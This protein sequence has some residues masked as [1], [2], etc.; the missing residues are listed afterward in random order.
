MSLWGGEKA[1][2]KALEKALG[3]PKPAAVPAPVVAEPVLTQVL[4]DALSTPVPGAEEDD[5]TEACWQTY[6]RLPRAE[7]YFDAA[8]GKW[9]KDEVCA[10]QFAAKA[11]A[12]PRNNQPR[13]ETCC[14]GQLRKDFF[15]EVTM[16]GIDGAPETVEVCCWGMCFVNPCHSRSTG[17]AF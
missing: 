3:K 17:G 13:P 9:F 5:G 2:K 10:R 12:Q 15:Y 16:A 7:M 4:E 14:C 8:Q 11:A 6:E 1:R